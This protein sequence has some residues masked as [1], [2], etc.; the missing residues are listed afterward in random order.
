MKKALITGVIT[1][2]LAPSAFAQD[3]TQ[4][5]QQNPAQQATS[6]PTSRPADQSAQ[7]RQQEF[8]ELE[9][10]ANEEQAQEGQRAPIQQQAKQEQKQ[11]QGWTLGLGDEKSAFSEWGPKIYIERAQARVRGF[12]LSNGRGTT[13]DDTKRLEAAWIVNGRASVFKDLLSVSVGARSGGDDFTQPYDQISG[14]DGQDVTFHLRQFFASVNLAAVGIPVKVSAG[15][16]PTVIG[17]GT[18]A[19][20]LS[21]EGNIM[22][23]QGSVDFSDILPVIKVLQGTVGRPDFAGRNQDLGDLDQLDTIRRELHKDDIYINVLVTA[24]ALKG[25][26]KGSLDWTRFNRDDN[27]RLALRVKLTDFLEVMGEANV[28]LEDLDEAAYSA[29]IA[30]KIIEGLDYEIRYTYVNR[31][32]A[33]LGQGG[34]FTNNLG[35]GH[36]LGAKL[37]YYFGCGFSVFGSVAKDLE[38]LDN[39][40]QVAGEVGVQFD[41]ARFFSEQFSKKEKKPASGEQSRREG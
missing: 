8:D 31:G 35:E 17:E 36:Q 22:G 2:C 41:L 33:Y 14:G 11:E 6:R 32:F 1:A 9:E 27:L 12:F 18:D 28:G 19:T 37:S 40:S 34:Q 21:A 4:Q 38:E 39:S 20:T 15:A 29:A 25:R 24:E 13:K 10:M 30:G 7:A 3:S 5:A 26:I 23:Y 16:L